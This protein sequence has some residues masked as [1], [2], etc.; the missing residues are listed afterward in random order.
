M[1]EE[2]ADQFF[3]TAFVGL[4]NVE[5]MNELYPSA[6]S[7]TTDG[8][9]TYL[10]HQL[11]NEIGKTEIEVYTRK[12]RYKLRDNVLSS[13]PPLAHRLLQVLYFV[14]REYNHQKADD[15]TDEDVYRV[16]LLKVGLH[17]TFLPW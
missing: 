17:R 10:S 9:L 11:V 6:F 12:K 1:R 15:L 2:Y 5:E 16:M 8:M 14:F 7:M 13:H 4:A 3:A